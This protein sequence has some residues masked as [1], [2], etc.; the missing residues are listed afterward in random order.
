MLALRAQIGDGLNDYGRVL[1][2]DSHAHASLGSSTVQTAEGRY[3]WPWPCMPK[4]VC[5]ATPPPFVGRD[6]ETMQLRWQV[7]SP[8]T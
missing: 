3:C 7:N 6:A 4:S 2:V 8:F 1:V 5:D